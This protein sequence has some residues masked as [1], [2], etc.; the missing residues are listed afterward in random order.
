MN[1]SYR[2]TKNFR[3]SEER[4]IEVELELPAYR[5]YHGGYATTYVKLY[6]NQDGQLCDVA[7]SVTDKHISDSGAQVN[8]NFEIE[9]ESPH[10]FGYSHNFYMGAGGESEVINEAEYTKIMGQVMHN[11]LKMLG[12]FD[13]S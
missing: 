5:K 13:E 9:F 2:F 3:T 1:Q 11:L 10:K 4:E 12:V 6:N 7:I 8:K